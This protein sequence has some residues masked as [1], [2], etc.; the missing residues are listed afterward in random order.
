MNIN[1][2]APLRTVRDFIRYAL[3]RLSES[4]ISYGHGF[5][6]P[7]DEAGFIVLRL[8]SIPLDYE[9][10]FLDAA[11]TLNER[12]KILSA[13]SDRC[14]R[15]VPTAYI[16]KEWWLTGHPFYVDERVLIPRSYIAELLEEKLSPWIDSPEDI[17][18]VLDLCTGSAC[19]AILAS[20]TFP[21]ALV[22]AADISADA[23]EVAD[24]N[25]DDYQLG[26]IVSPIQSDLFDNLEGRKY[27]LII[28]NPPYVTREAMDEL[29]EEYRHEPALALE[30]GDDGMDV[31]RRIIAQ[32]KDHLTENG[33]LVV[34]L[35]DGKEA[36]VAIWPDLPVTWLSTSGGDD[37]VFMI[38]RKDLP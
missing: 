5:D 33:I 25:I 35:G 18:S 6:N 12:E 20:E 38:H 36:F 30:A 24:I 21:N 23:L 8:L 19:L 32:A 3:T 26:G 9:E 27:D 11:L 34:E 7:C 16:T 37:Q 31:I 15:L 2:S 1:S 29:P 4:G 10:K 17:R 22:D 13:I 28:S 14:D